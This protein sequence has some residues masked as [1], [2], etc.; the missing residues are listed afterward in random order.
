M[1][2]FTETHTARSA[3]SFAASLSLSGC[4]H[5]HHA[6]SQPKNAITSVVS[7]TYSMGIMFQRATCPCIC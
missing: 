2:N 1:I 3:S 6:P 7:R 4:R 5:D